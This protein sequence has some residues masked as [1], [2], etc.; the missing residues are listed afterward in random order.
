MIRE[1]TE[2]R[3]A[4]L[5]YRELECEEQMWDWEGKDVDPNV[6][7]KLLTDHQEFFKEHVLGRDI[8]LT[9]RIPNPSADRV[10]R[11]VLLEA[12]E[13]IPRCYDTAKCLYGEE[14]PPPVFEVILPLTTSH[15]ELLKVSS[16]YSEIIVGKGRARLGDGENTSLEEWI[17]EFAPKK[18]EVIP[19][20]EDKDSLCNINKILANYVEYAKPSYLRV[21][22]ARSDPALNYGLFSAV[23][24]VKTALS[25]IYKLI[26]NLGLDIFPV[27]GTGSLPFRGHLTPHNIDSFLEEYAGARTVT[28]QSALKYD[29]EQLKVK[30]T[31]QKLNK[32]LVRRDA[33]ILSIEEEF[34]LKNIVELLSR[35][36]QV[37]IERFPEIINFLAKFV[38][39]R[40]ARKLHIG[41][42]GYSRQV[43]SIRLPRAIEFTA[44]TY[45]LGIPPELVGVSALSDLSEMDW[46]LFNEYYVNWR[47][48]L[49]FASGFISW[50]NLN[51]LMKD[52][53]VVEKVTRRFG[54]E[55]VIPE[56]MKDLQFLEENMGL[57]LGP[58]SPDHRRHENIANSV[59]ISLIDEPTEIGRYIV[60]AARIRRSLG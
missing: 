39:R 45:S 5:A 23:L 54:L 52:K 27:I 28:I 33:R 55:Q 56:I 59:L 13:S 4:Y 17:G 22:L 37:K 31:V 14:A 15:L 32:E 30:E 40:R 3:E 16:C 25:K 46:N 42:F 43:G 8:F 57:K 29:F 10:E 51:D 34:R 41:L 44:V 18:V 53:E 36:Y 48:D 21:F 58:R 24:L 19:L 12:L 26:Q 49:K 9:Y 20:I 60:E 11:K 6:V 2:V 1:E 7:R 50:R 38:P 35:N 47:R